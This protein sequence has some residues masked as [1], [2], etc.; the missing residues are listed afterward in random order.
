MGKKRSPRRDEEASD[1]PETKADE[2][3]LARIYVIAIFFFEPI[4]FVPFNAPN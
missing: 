4:A 3:L 1:F 2:N